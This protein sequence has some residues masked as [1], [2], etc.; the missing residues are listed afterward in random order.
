MSLSNLKIQ[1]QL[2]QSI[3][4]GD[5]F[6]AEI[7]A[8][9]HNIPEDC[10]FPPDEELSPEDEAFQNLW[11]QQLGIVE[12]RNQRT[13][14]RLDAKAEFL[15]NKSGS[16]SRNLSQRIERYGPDHPKTIGYKLKRLI[17]QTRYMFRKLQADPNTDPK[18]IAYYIKRLD[19]LEKQ[20]SANYERLRKSS[21]HDPRITHSRLPPPP[22]EPAPY[23]PPTE[24]DST[25]LDLTIDKDNA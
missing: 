18:R 15:K 19:D 17:D 14:N 13:Q 25:G 24:I 12:K 7:K 8:A 5:A 3:A 20:R 11:R 9:C 22:P 21:G 10:I 16:R 6:L 4:I 23:F 1:S 2:D